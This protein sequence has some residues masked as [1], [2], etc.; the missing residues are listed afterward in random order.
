M[1]FKQGHTKHEYTSGMA[2]ENVFEFLQGRAEKKQRKEVTNKENET[3]KQSSDA[4][5]EGE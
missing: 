2:I 1:F 4:N 3:D 5:N